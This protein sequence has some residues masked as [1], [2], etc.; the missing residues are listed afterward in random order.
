MFSPS[1][2]GVFIPERPFFCLL[3]KAG[4]F[5]STGGSDAGANNGRFRLIRAQKKNGA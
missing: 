2:P 3:Y 4:A 5:P 1:F